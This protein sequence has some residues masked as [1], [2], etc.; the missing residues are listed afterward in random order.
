MVGAIPIASWIHLL[1]CRLI[2][3]GQGLS[4]CI[5]VYYHLKLDPA[6]KLVNSVVIVLLN[7]RLSSIHISS[8][9]DNRLRK[10]NCGSY[11]P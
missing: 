3:I 11:T 6:L 10:L 8:I 2:D 5:Q 4:E 1:L 7:Y 9:Y